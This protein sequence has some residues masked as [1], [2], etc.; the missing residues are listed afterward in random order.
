MKR[1]LVLL[2][3]L[4]L[5]AGSVTTAE[6]KRTRKPRRIERTVEGSY[7]AL[8]APVTGCNEPLGSYSCMVVDAR[9]TEVFFTAKVMD[10]HGQPVYVQ[11]VNG[12]GGDIGAFCGEMTRPISFDPASGL[13]FRIE[14]QPYFWS[15][16]GLDWLGPMNCPYRVKTTGTISVTL[17]NLP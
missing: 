7:G 13:E 14:P 4:G 15:H 3:V 12:G 1:F 8:P 2:M 9:P 6:A 10:A 16:W 17:S 5:I 11:V